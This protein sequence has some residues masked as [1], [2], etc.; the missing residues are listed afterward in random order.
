VSRKL[1][2][3]DTFQPATSLNLLAAAWL[4]FMVHDWLSHGSNDKANPFQIPLEP[5]DPWPDRPMTILRTR[6]DPTRSPADD[7]S[8]PTFANTATHWWDA[9]QL[10]GADP[11]TV[12]RLRAGHDG[13]LSVDPDGLLPLDPDTG[14]DLTGVNGNYWIGLSLFHTLF[15]HEHN[16]ICDRLKVEYPTWSDDELFDHARL[17]TAALLAKI[18]TIE[19]TPAIIAHPTTQYALHGNWYGLEGEHLRRVFGRLSDSEVISGIPGMPNADHHGVAYSIT[20]EFV[21]VYRMHPL[22]PDDLVFR[23]CEDDHVLAELTF[24]DVAFGGSRSTMQR[25]GL[26]D[27]FY[28]AGRMHPGAITLHNYPKFLQHLDKPDSPLN[29][30]AS[31]DVLR[32]RERG[33]PRYNDF[34]ELL[35]KPRVR[36]FQEM[37]DN[38]VWASEL[39][40]VYGDVD[41]VDLMVGMYAEP[42]PQG[43]GFSDTAFRIFILMA[44]RRLES[45]RF[46]THDYTPEVYTQFGLDWIDRNGLASVLL[47]HAP[48]LAPALRGVSNP[49][50]PWNQVES[51]GTA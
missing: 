5:D 16:A 8:P 27:G 35:H 51:G 14:T 46:F 30:L 29:D 19:W 17:I 38:P 31:I 13:K 41:K 20:E 49:F 42:R 44:S 6:A 24:P 23:S 4:Q 28:S 22:I 32:I 10:Y 2:T 40:E 39:E 1:L 34:R 36:S 18:H 9:S 45:D 37:T 12:D 48:A 47:R 43:F 21:A 26:R 11:G 25:V 15:A 33:V 3:R 7:G 50:T